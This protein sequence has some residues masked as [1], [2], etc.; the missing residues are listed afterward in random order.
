MAIQRLTLQ[1]CPCKTY[2]S[3]VGTCV[4]KCMKNNLPGRSNSLIRDMEIQGKYFSK[5]S[6]KSETHSVCYFVDMYQ[7]SKID[8]QY[9]LLMSTIKLF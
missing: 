1:L 3:S 9:Y 8:A 4:W 6:Y 2:L 7:N 5:D